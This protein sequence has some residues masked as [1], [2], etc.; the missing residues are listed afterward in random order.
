MPGIV[1]PIGGK[2]EQAVLL[3]AVVV[4]LEYSVSS[5]FFLIYS[6]P[7]AGAPPR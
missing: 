2:Q 3:F 6:V 7:A 5:S 4:H 1:V